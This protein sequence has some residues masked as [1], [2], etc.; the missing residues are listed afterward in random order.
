MLLSGSGR[1]SVERSENVQR[2][3]GRFG[4]CSRAASRKEYIEAL[5]LLLDRHIKQ[6]QEW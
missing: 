4:I 1:N 6:R 2:M 5:P 3:L